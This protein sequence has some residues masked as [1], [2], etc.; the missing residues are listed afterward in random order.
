MAVTTLY[1]VIGARADDDAETI[2]NA[3]RDAV[4]ASHP[5]LH[6]A[7]PRSVE[8][9]RQII[10][11]NAILSDPDQRAVYDHLLA[12]ERWQE[13]NRTRR[14]I[15]VDSLRNLAADVGTVVLLAALLGGGYLIFMHVAKSSVA[16]VGMTEMA[17]SETTP[18]A[19]GP[20]ED[21]VGR[22]IRLSREELHELLTGSEPSTPA[23]VAAPTESE[24]SPAPKVEKSPPDAST[25]SAA[26]GTMKAAA[27]PASGAGDAVVQDAAQ[28]AA[29]EEANAGQAR[30]AAGGAAPNSE[31]VKVT[32]TGIG[33]SR[34]GEPPLSEANSADAKVGKVN[35]GE[36]QTVDT[37][38]S[39]AQ[40]NDPKFYFERGM[41]SYRNGDLDRALANFNRAILLDPNFT[42]AYV[43]RSIV[44]Y[45]KSEI[46]RAFAD[47]AR[48]TR[49]RDSLMLA[50]RSHRAA[51][52][53]PR[54]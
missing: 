44:F 18:P 9:F 24:A 34:I 48:A 42:S 7:D 29:T 53:A 3:F 50:T 40:S 13:R 35:M 47:V 5:D 14:G 19:R 30:R 37:D 2:K 15:V 10:Y 6:A 20:Q 46:G 54:N 26:D 51:G 25:P 43:N 32:D 49:L 11:A 27:A 28:L 52:A 17:V 16:A 12:F 23:V 8:R 1:E 36:S 21:Q 22:G 33:N 38:A 41:A 45:R 4:K 31:D 39:E